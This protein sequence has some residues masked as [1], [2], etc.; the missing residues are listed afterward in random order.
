[1]A[2]GS[3]TLVSASVSAWPAPL[4]VRVFTRHPPLGLY[5]PCVSS[6]K[7]TVSD[8]IKGLPTPGRL[9]LNLHLNSG[10]KDST[11]K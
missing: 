6:Y 10:D 8:R 5:L 1:M 7:D 9:H 11:S 2:A 4:G 3:M